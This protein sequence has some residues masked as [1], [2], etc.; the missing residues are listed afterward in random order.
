M[1]DIQIYWI[2]KHTIPL[3][4]GKI[5]TFIVEKF[6]YQKLPFSGLKEQAEAPFLI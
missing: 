4:K 2:N 3:G 5:W 1:A 6:N